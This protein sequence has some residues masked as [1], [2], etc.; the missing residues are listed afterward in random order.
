MRRLIIRILMYT[1]GT[2]SCNI[3]RR[4][5]GSFESSG[6]KPFIL[7][8]EVIQVEWGAISVTVLLA[9]TATAAVFISVHQLGCTRQPWRL[10]NTQHVSPR[11]SQE[12]PRCGELQ[13][14]LH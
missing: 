14:V 13:L 12:L 9:P 3:G 4:N 11:T 6:R 7:L 2:G 10:V 5:A 1:T 8:D